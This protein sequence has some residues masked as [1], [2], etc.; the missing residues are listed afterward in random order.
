MGGGQL[1]ATKPEGRDGIGDSPK[2]QWHTSK[3][4]EKL[5]PNMGEG[6]LDIRG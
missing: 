5:T 4:D 1:T 2:V 6:G 3:V